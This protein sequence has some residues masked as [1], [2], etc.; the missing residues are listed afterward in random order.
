MQIRNKNLT[1]S[2][3]NKLGPSETRWMERSRTYTGIAKDM[4]DQWGKL[5]GT[6]LK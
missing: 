1:P 2:G 6:D 4:A 3:Q 5:G